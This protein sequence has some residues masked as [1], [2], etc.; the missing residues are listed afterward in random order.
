MYLI[1]FSSSLF[2]CFFVCFFVSS[3]FLTYGLKFLC[4]LALVTF[5]YY[6]DPSW[7]LSIKPTQINVDR[8]DG[9][10]RDELEYNNSI[11]NT[12]TLSLFNGYINK[13]KKKINQ[14][15]ANANSSTVVNSS[16]IS[17]SP[18]PRSINNSAKRATFNSSV[19]NADNAS[20]NPSSLSA[21]A[22]RNA[23]S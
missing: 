4:S 14:S 21:E 18:T 2:V 19:P 5:A 11:T 23:A 1:L 9:E 13:K 8:H 20:V 3:F 17:R 10:E 7:I 15:S 6:C 12:Y 22:A 16:S